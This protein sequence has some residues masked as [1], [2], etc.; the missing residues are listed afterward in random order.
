MEPIKYLI[1]YNLFSDP[2]AMDTCPVSPNHAMWDTIAFA[3]VCVLIG[4]LIGFQVCS[5][6]KEE[7]KR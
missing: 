6:E 5:I 1:Y 7:R 4:Y 2:P 3:L